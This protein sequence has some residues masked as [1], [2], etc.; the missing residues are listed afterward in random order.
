MLD[1]SSRLLM[2]RAE[3][4]L[5]QSFIITNNGGGGGT[6]ALSIVAKEKPDG[7]HLSCCVSNALTSLPQIRKV[8][9]KMEDFVPI[10]EF[11]AGTSVIVVKADAPWKTLKELVEYAKKNPMK[12]RYSTSGVFGNHHLAM[13]FIGLKEG[14]QWTHVPYSGGEPGFIGLLGG[15]VEV[16]VG[17][18]G[19]THSKDGTVRLLAT[20]NERR[21]KTVPEV[22]TLS[23]SGY[24]FTLD[25][26]CMFSAPKGTPSSIIKKLEEAFRKGAEDREFIESIEKTDIV[27][28]VYRNSEELE[29]FLQ[30]AYARFGKMIQEFNIPRES[31]KK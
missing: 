29:K 9:Y 8:S 13:L 22:P 31:E 15:H 19:L 1:I 17:A 11:G 20:L 2:S 28:I 26:A 27:Q 7:Y 12:I 25:T 16:N 24:D 10:M 6:V 30:R 14:I 23:E 21:F 5:G 3:K 18:S 4:Y